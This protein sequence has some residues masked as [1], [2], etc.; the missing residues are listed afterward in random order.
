L[1]C[2]RYEL[3]FANST[4]T[5]FYVEPGLLLYL[6]IYFLFGETN[7]GQRINH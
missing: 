4:A 5:K 3:D 1:Q 6:T 2:L 7:V